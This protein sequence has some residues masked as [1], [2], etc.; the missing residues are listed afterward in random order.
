VPEPDPPAGLPTAPA[1][2]ATPLVFAHRG[3]SAALPEHTVDAY[4]RAMADGADGLEC[5]VRMTRDGHLICHHDRRLG[6]TSNGR[7]PVSARN[8]DELHLLDFGSWRAGAGPASVLTLDRLLEV[9]R[10]AGRPVRLLIDVKYPGRYGAHLERRLVALLGRH[11]L[12][13][14][15]PDDPVRVSVMSFSPI[16]VRRIRRLAPTLPAVQLLNLLP[17]GVRLGRLPAGTR[18]AGPS[19]RLVR[20][21]PALVP[22]LRAAGNQVYVWTVNDRADIDLVVRQGV[23]GI[24]T[25]RPAE[26]LVHLGR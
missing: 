21:R 4:L 17:P 13:P 18:I 25:D 11:G 3:A 16:A 6:R 5:D 1:G 24:I 2:V 10:A 22:A 12:A 14:P 23:D 8:L 20:A 15:A 26:T 9:I 7:G 19:L